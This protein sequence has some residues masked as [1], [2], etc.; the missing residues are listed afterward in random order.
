M[1]CQ[2][3]IYTF[4]FCIYMYWNSIFIQFGCDTKI[5]ISY[6]T[7]SFLQAGLHH[8]SQTYV[9][10]KL[11]IPFLWFLLVWRMTFHVHV[12]F[13]MNSLFIR[14][15]WKILKLNIKKFVKSKLHNIN[16]F[17]TS[18]FLLNQLNWTCINYIFKT[19]PYYKMLI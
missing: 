15:S 10:T 8:L 3:L 1:L 4:W 11:M 6:G 13:L 5:V 2:I 19:D 14:L 16:W 12:I 7:Q 9:Y 18:P 17:I